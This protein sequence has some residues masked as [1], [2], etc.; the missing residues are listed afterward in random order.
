MTCLEKPPTP[1]VRGDDAGP[2]GDTRDEAGSGNRASGVPDIPITPDALGAREIVVF[3]FEG[4]S[5][6]FAAWNTLTN[7]TNVAGTRAA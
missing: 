3:F 7:L 4:Q 5:S 2:Q 6:L 1:S